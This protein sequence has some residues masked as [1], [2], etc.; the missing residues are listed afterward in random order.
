MASGGSD[1]KVDSLSLAPILDGIF[2]YLAVKG[3]LHSG[4][5]AVFGLNDVE[6]AAL[7]KRFPGEKTQLLNGTHVSGQ[8]LQVINALS[9]L[10]YQVV[11]ST[12]EAE[13]TW[14]LRREI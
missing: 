3:S 4:D 13:I 8:V 9:E 11:T 5:C 10:G 12:G 7:K 2:V 14:T 1:P 6:R